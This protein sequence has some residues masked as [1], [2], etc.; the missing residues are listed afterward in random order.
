MGPIKVEAIVKEY[1]EVDGLKFP[2]KMLQKMQ[3]QEMEFEFSKIQVNP[4][5]PKDTFELPEKIKK[6][7]EKQKEKKSEEDEAKTSDDKK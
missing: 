3:G 5:F 1:K 6:L 2:S 7:V 4:E